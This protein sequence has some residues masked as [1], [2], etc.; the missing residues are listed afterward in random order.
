MDQSTIAAISTPLG[1]GG[2]GVI[3][4]S[5]PEALSIMDKLFVKTCQAT[6]PEG[7]KKGPHFFKSHRVY[8]GHIVDP[9]QEKVIDE[10]L[11]IYMQAPNS[12][13]REDVVEIQAHS[14]YV[15]LDRLLNA[16]LDSGA[17]LSE[18]GE[19]TKRA[20][21]NGRIDL[22]Q[23]EAV[24]DLINAPCEAAVQM[25]NRQMSG[26]LKKE[27]EQIV[28]G[29]MNIRSRLEADLEFSEGGDANIAWKNIETEITS[30]ILEP[31]E[32]LIQAQKDTAIYRDGVHLS[33]G[34][35]PNV[36]K[37][38]LLN[39]LVQKETAIVS[40]VPGTTRDVIREYFSINGIPVVICDTAGLHDSDDPIEIIGIQKAHEQIEC[41][42][43]LL[44]VVDATREISVNEEKLIE[45][46]KEKKTFFLINK[47]DIACEDAI[48]KLVKKI[49]H[50]QIF[51]ISAKTGMGIDSL[52]A[53]IFKGIVSADAV[54]SYDHAMPNLRQRKV[55]EKAQQQ[56]QACLEASNTMQKEDLVADMLK[57]A[58]QTLDEVG[59]QRK[60]DDLYEQ[61]F[62]QFCIGK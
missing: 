32:K 35:V 31:I 17:R 49:K 42:D 20:F 39:Q 60:M 53:Q 10:V 8:Y 22:T 41:A 51:S 5:G 13:T 9:K 62:N 45:K 44:F 46:Y 55:L 54:M 56:I 40:E 2:I 25:A 28:S 23:A 7:A 14:G 59:G 58:V 47:I 50:P 34:G 11:A 1:P 43:V 36:G 4:I 18:P 12:F 29:I 57:N 61:I 33:I 30:T 27:V 52:I 21:L 48:D 15:V 3:R 19:F 6:K 24:I 38:S 26:L 16:V 37:S